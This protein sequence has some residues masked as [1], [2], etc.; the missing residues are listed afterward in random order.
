MAVCMSSASATTGKAVAWLQFQ[1]AESI[2]MQHSTSSKGAPC[3]AV[4]VD[5]MCRNLPEAIRKKPHGFS[6]QL[7]SLYKVKKDITFSPRL[8]SMVA[9]EFVL[10]EFVA[11]RVLS[12]WPTSFCN[13]SF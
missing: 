13:L 7:A 4:V 3:F 6:L 8:W 10:N 1:S 2:P 5:A 9:Q 12:L 11:N